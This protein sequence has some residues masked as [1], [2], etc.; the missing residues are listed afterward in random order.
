MHA[1]QERDYLQLLDLEEF[2]LRSERRISI[3]SVVQS[4]KLLQQ[5]S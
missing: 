2:P 4:K 1:K 3:E 5:L